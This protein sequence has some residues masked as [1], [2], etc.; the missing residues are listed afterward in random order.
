MYFKSMKGLSDVSDVSWKLLRIYSL[1]D[2]DYVKIRVLES[3]SK[4]E[5]ADTTCILLV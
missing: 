1:V 5:A 3:I 4:Y 2:S